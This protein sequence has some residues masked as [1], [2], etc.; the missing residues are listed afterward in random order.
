MDFIKNA[1]RD[2]PDFPKKGIIFKD[3][4]PI[5][6]DPKVYKKTIDVLAEQYANRNIDKI[7]AIESRGFLFG[8][9]LAYK[10]DIGLAIVRKP[11]K[12]P[13]KT[14]V[15]T[16]DLEYGTDSLEI[17]E[18]SLEKGDKVLIIDDLLATGGTAEATANLVERVG[19][20]VE[21]IC[22]IVELSFLG[23]KNKLEKYSVNSLISY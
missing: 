5:L 19:A 2:I 8:T 15:E 9:V 22:F 21:E 14:I 13:Y 11:G 12:L 17:H 6:L 10:L 4:T 1:I 23:G 18:D 3:I 20:S 7:V 16:Y